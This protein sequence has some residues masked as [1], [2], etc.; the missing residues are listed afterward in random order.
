[1]NN[2]A[3]IAG[4]AVL[5][6]VLAASVSGL[7]YFR[8][9]FATHYPVKVLSAQLYR[10]GE[11]PF[12]NFYAGGGQPLG[13]NPNTLTFYPDNVLYLFLPAHVAFN[14]HFWLHLIAG[15]FAMRGLCRAAGASEW[16]SRTAALLYAL[17]GV[18]ISSLAFYNLVTAVALIPAALLATERLLRQPSVL[19]ALQLGAVLGV[20]GLAVEPVTVFGVALAMLIVAAFSLR[21]TSTW[22]FAGGGLA[23]LGV[24]LLIASPQLI[25]YREIAHEVERGQHAFSAQTALAASLPPWRLLELIVGPFRGLIT[26]LGPGAFHVEQGAW[27]PLFTSVFAGAL[28]VPALFR[29]KTSRPYQVVFAVSGFLALGAFNPLVRGAIEASETLR[30]ARYPEK[31]VL[32]MAVALAVLIARAL[33]DLGALRLWTLLALAPLAVVALD[34]ARRGRSSFAVLLIAAP[35]A[36]GLAHLCIADRTMADRIAGDRPETGRPLLILLAL[37]FTPTLFWAMRGIPLDWFS[38]YERP[39]A[40]APLPLGT[41]PRIARLDP[42][43]PGIDGGT[44]ARQE[45]RVRARMLDPDFGIAYGFRYALERSPEGMYSFLSRIV[46]ERFTAAPPPMKMRYLRMLSCHTL[47]SRRPLEPDAKPVA[48]AD[49]NALFAL[50]IRAPLPYVTPVRQTIGVRSLQE[51]V[52]R[53]ESPAF[54]EHST[55]IVPASLASVPAPATI[56]SVKVEPQELTIAVDARA[57]AL[58]IVN[59]SWFSA[60]TAT[61]GGQELRTFPANIDRLGIAIPAGRSTITVRFGRKRQSVALAWAASML[62]LLAAAATT[63]QGRRKRGDSDRSSGPL[64]S[65]PV[66]D[67]V[68]FPDH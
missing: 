50:P 9:D 4:L 21:N 65:T 38:P 57:P 27:P 25:A 22:R 45:Y 48:V 16:S 41:G 6:G 31:F 58:L 44:S 15:F 43:P 34:L 12:W 53:I 10:A 47:F 30:V 8:D 18:A 64:R 63:F 32:I 35:L 3:R 56:A 5:L 37:V 55:S 2:A 60:W 62:L 24:A 66:F 1:M 11:L 14:L 28:A 51:A 42:Q 23:A 54:D 7:F 26:D 67:S 29:R 46:Q 49:R 59:E 52:A 13:G 61:A 39:A 17:G 33:D 36:W 68:A 20:L 40:L 19:R